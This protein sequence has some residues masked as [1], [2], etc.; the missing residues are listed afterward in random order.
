MQ[1]PA[2]VSGIEVLKWE[3]NGRRCEVPSVAHAAWHSP[4]GRHGVVLANWT[5]EDRTV[6]V[7]DPRFGACA[8]I[9]AC[10]R[11][12][13]RSTAKTKKTGVEVDLPSLS[14]ALVADE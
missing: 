4:D 11:Q 2:D 8:V 14:C 3:R 7:S 5:T 13:A 6:T 10:G 12:I 1:R 9:T